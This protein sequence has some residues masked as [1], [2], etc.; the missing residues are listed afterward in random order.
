MTGCWGLGWRSAEEEV[1]ASL[2]PEDLT[3]DR[4]PLKTPA[5]PVARREGAMLATICP[6]RDEGGNHSN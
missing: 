2:P 5:C 3:L 4:V 1:A 6:L